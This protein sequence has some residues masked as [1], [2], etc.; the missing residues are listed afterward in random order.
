[1]NLGERGQEPTRPATVTSGPEK[2]VCRSSYLRISADHQAFTMLA[3][4]T[5]LRLFKGNGVE[6]PDTLIVEGEVVAS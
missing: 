1:M 2:Y 3:V 4:D 6:H 5:H